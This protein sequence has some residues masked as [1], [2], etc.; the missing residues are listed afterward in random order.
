MTASVDV[1]ASPDRLYGRH[2]GHP[3]RP[4]QQRLLD[5]TLPRLRFPP[6]A[7]TDPASAFAHPPREIWLE[8]GFG[9]GEHSLAQ[10]RAHP[11][12]G[13]IACEVF[14]NGLC[15]LLSRLVPDDQEGDAPIPDML[16]IWDEDARILLREL[17]DASIDRAFLMFPDPWPK[18]RHAKRRFIHPDTVRMMA[19]ILKPGAIWQVASDDP[20]YQAW[21]EEVM[22]AQTLFRTAPP[23]LE[24]PEGWP[25]TRYETKALKAGRQPFYWTF[26]RN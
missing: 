8:V 9:S 4:R 6:S 17:P 15:S 7:M 26:V 5:L 11:D 18:A 3:L 12:V 14:E 16:R 24:R 25:P 13:Y 22:G 10:N 21:V 20:T 2:R 19:R 23:V 1:K